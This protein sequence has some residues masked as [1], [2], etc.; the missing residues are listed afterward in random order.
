MFSSPSDS[1]YEIR[2]GTIDQSNTAEVEWVS[3]PY[4]NTAKKR[5]HLTN[6][7]LDVNMF[8]I[9]IL[10]RRIRKDCSLN[11]IPDQTTSEQHCSLH[12]GSG[13]VN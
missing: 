5:K 6:D 7:W 13:D 10:P 2:L 4:M 9:N 12:I 11:E 1:V 8:V 3:R